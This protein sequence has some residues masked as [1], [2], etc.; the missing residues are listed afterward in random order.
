MLRWLNVT[1]VASGVELGVVPENMRRAFSIKD[2]ADGV[3]LCSTLRAYV[4]SLGHK[5]GPL[6]VINFG[7]R[8]FVDNDTPNIEEKV[9]GGTQRDE[10]KE[11]KGEGNNKSMHSAGYRRQREP[12]T[13]EE[14]AQNVD[15]L[16]K[17]LRQLDF[18]FVPDEADILR[19]GELEMLLLLTTVFNQLPQYYPKT[20][21]EFAGELGQSV[22]KA[23][24]LRN[25]T[26]RTLT[27]TSTLLGDSNFKFQGSNLVS[28]D[29]GTA[30]DCNLSFTSRFS[31]QAKAR[32]ELKS[33]RE[34][35]LLRSLLVFDLVSHVLGRQP[36]QTITAR[37]CQYNPQ[38]I[39]VQFT[40]PFDEACKFHVNLEQP[41]SPNILVGDPSI[42]S[43]HRSNR[44]NS[45]NASMSAANQQ[46]AIA[47]V[48]FPSSFA[49]AA[50]S[51]SKVD[52]DVI[53]EVEGGATATVEVFFVAFQAQR[54]VAELVFLDPNVGEFMYSLVV[55]V[56]P[57]EVE[58]KIIKSTVFRPSLQVHLSLQTASKRFKVAQTALLDFL[59]KS[60]RQSQYK[61]SLSMLEA[62]QAV[63]RH[64]VV[65]I[66]SPFYKGS[67]EVH[68][69]AP[70]N[71]DDPSLNGSNVEPAT[72]FDL[73]LQP[74]DDGKYPCNVVLRSA[75]E[76][77][78]YEVQ[79]E[80]T[81]EGP[82]RVLEFT[83]HAR[84]AITQDI[85]IV[86]G[87]DTT[88]AIRATLKGSS[89]FSGPPILKIPAMSTGHYK[90][91]YKPAWIGS[92]K[93]S[94][95]LSTSDGKYSFT[96]VLVGEA[97]DP[98]AMDHIKLE[99]KA[100]DKLLHEFVVPNASSRAI[101]YEVES[102][103]PQISGDSV[104]V[105]PPN[106]E[107][108]YALAVTP[109]VGGTYSGSVTFRD[110]ATGQYMWYTVEIHAESPQAEDELEVYAQT[111]KAVS[112]E[113]SLG[114]PL[115][116]NV[117]FEV[118]MRGDGLIG[119]AN[120]S[121]AAGD[122]DATYELIYSPLVAG[123]FHGSVTF[124][125]EKLG[126]FWYKLVLVAQP[127]PPTELEPMCCGVGS[128]CTQ[129]ITIDN[130]TDSSLTLVSHTSNMT[131]YR[132]EPARITIPPYASRTAVVFY[133][134]S[135]IDKEE[136][137]VITLSHRRVGDIVYHVIGTGS[138]PELL[139]PQHVLSALHQGKSASFQFRNPF[140]KALHVQLS[141]VQ[142][143][144]TSHCGD[145]RLLARHAEVEI[146]P[147]AQLHIPFLFI[148]RIIG[149]CRATLSVE[150]SAPLSAI[151]E[152]STFS[153]DGNTKLR[154]VLPI[155]GETE[156]N[157][158]DVQLSYI[159]R[160]R[161]TLS[162]TLSMKVPGFE[163]IPDLEADGFTHFSFELVIPEENKTKIEKALTID[164]VK[165]TV[166]HSS[167]SVNGDHKSDTL[168]FAL[169]FQP[170]IMFSE[171]IELRVRKD[172]GGVWRYPLKLQVTEPEVDD[173]IT[174]EAKLHHTSSVSF[175]LTNVEPAP[176]QFKA[177]FSAD[178][179]VEFNVFPQK[180]ELAPYGSREGTSFVLSFTPQDY[181]KTAVGKLI[182]QTEEM[183][184]SYEVR[185]RLPQYI[186]PTLATSVSKI[187][188]GRGQSRSQVRS[189]SKSR[190]R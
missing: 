56:D 59:Q 35:G 169:L 73:V 42:S 55:D 77:R 103:L 33:S 93:A 23:L 155:E 141:L 130:P 18:V 19:G 180:G 58:D 34:D 13:E 127:A 1:H 75:I 37:T 12:L 32:L 51:T 136:P 124:T 74:K 14:A 46:G 15:K 61:T 24:A 132:I 4:P 91:V 156:V 111:R 151:G 68:L 175:D 105:V 131:N 67:S 153:M 145:Y 148:P 189:K 171:I 94:L 89:E 39:K 176:A 122:T 163:N 135:S 11:A 100:R 121:L 85:P 138:L 92:E 109:P 80:V 96:Y 147:F 95:V 43:R 82:E 118:A 164:F 70:G 133:I 66:S 71:T 129:E 65:D 104:L 113:I 125:N 120:F 181:G 146:A 123:T 98:L 140:D 152:R 27:Y 187:D 177:Y 128:S 47:N 44:S 154:W 64:F 144:T 159:C 16:C 31:T 184:W 110:T 20:E 102:D 162:Q 72:N 157:V 25:P 30:V 53:L 112:I 182:V 41:A 168:Q 167:S 52:G 115:P 190:R 149:E 22:Q 9:Q 40:N 69:Q 63:P 114:N 101:S 83:T 142:D 29:A 170:L 185:G 7:S 97:K 139:T 50:S 57:P 158:S 165:D 38:T 21:I 150:A 174:I 8:D 90:L 178:S 108:A 48:C 160:A 6:E 161:E 116:E 5:G 179:P 10:A 49:L 84:Q 78:V 81:S 36:Q 173:Q 126:E 2:I 188:S 134:P 60:Q 106:S 172:T 86:N 99:C 76:T 28:V 88:W 79:L 186:K 119:D 54:H 183:M 62:I 26:T 143:E 17:A 45:N 107:K 117:V 166:A 3:L 87:T 137:C